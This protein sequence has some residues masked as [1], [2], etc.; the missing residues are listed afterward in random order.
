M[1]TAP[2]LAQSASTKTRATSTLP[3]APT[4]KEAALSAAILVATVWDGRLTASTTPILDTQPSVVPPTKN[5]QVNHTA[6]VD[7]GATG[8]YLDAA[9]E[10]HCINV[11][12][13][14]TGPSVQVA[15]GYNTETSKRVIF[16]LAEELST[17]AKVGHIFDSLKSGSLISIG[18]LYDD[19]CVALFTKFNVNIYKDG[20]I[21]TVGK[22]NDTNG[23][24]NIPLAP[25]AAPTPTILKT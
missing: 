18:Q 9:S 23:L 5:H 1:A 10:Q 17:Q 8:H 22:T 25:K 14:D 19:D 16:P 6:I 21:I 4:C 24:C 2:T 12:S 7:T 3:P 15:N 11:Q 13:T 20:K